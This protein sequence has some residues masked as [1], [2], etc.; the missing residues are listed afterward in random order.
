MLVNIWEAGEW[1]EGSECQ[2]GGL[3]EELSGADGAQTRWGTLS[4]VHVWCPEQFKMQWFT[5]FTYTDSLCIQSHY[6]HAND[7]LI[8]LFVRLLFYTMG[9]IPGKPKTQNF[10]VILGKCCNDQFLW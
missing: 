8:C 6:I 7:T 9:N 5:T 3:K 2:L 1:D 4:S 10:L